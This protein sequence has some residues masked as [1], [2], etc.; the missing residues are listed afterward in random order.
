MSTDAQTLIHTVMNAKKGRRRKLSLY[1][2]FR[3]STVKRENENI[4]ADAIPVAIGLMNLRCAEAMRYGVKD[5]VRACLNT[6]GRARRRRLGHI[7]CTV[8]EEGS[9]QAP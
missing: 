9:A 2:C 4:M 6:R 5:Y 7:P 3:L 8:R 1:A